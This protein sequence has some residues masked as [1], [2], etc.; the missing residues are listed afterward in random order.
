MEKYLCITPTHIQ[1]I[2]KKKL[3]IVVCFAPFKSMSSCVNCESSCE[4][5]EYRWECWVFAKRCNRLTISIASISFGGVSVGMSSSSLRFL[6]TSLFAFLST[7]IRL[8]SLHSLNAGISSSTSTNSLA[9]RLRPPILTWTRS[10]AKSFKAAETSSLETSSLELLSLS[11]TL[12]GVSWLLE[13]IKPAVRKVLQ[14]VDWVTTCQAL[15]VQCTASR[16]VIITSSAELATAH[17]AITCFTR[18]CPAKAHH[19]VSESEE[20]QNTHDSDTWNFWW[21]LDQVIV[22][23]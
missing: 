18:F 21:C 20:D 11:I 5:R 6:S 14:M 22:V 23:L 3:S 15:F 16:A 8:L 17:R 10:M 4:T 19:V 12:E 13:Q 2:L 9:V 1:S 7:V